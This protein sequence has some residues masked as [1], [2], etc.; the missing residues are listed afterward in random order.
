MT[1]K[2]GT[3]GADGKGTW[4]FNLPAG[5]YDVQVTVPFPN[6]TVWDFPN[7]VVN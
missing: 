6:G 5:T 3:L 1:S 7:E 4:T 2:N